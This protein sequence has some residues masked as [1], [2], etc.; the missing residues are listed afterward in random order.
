[1]DDKER[2]LKAVREKNEIT[3]KGKTIKIIGD[4]STET[5]KVRRAWS[6]GFER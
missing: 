2:I 5:L 6:E 3:F 1:M 4:F